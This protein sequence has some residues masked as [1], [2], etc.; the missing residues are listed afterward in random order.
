MAGG[1]TRG[2]TKFIAVCVS[3]DYARGINGLKLVLPNP[4]GAQV[5]EADSSGEFQVCLTDSTA[6]L[7]G[8]LGYGLDALT[9]SIKLNL[10]QIFFL[11]N[12]FTKSYD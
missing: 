12:L 8:Q 9:A 2:A 10:N 1:A 3:T 6:W 7:D 5:T 11:S 4:L